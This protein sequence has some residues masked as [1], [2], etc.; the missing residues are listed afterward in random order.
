[1]S[2]ACRHCDRKRERERAL[3]VETTDIASTKKS[4]R[5][6]SFRE[7]ERERERETERQR[8][9]VYLFDILIYEAS[10]EFGKERAYGAAVCLPLPRV[11][12]LLCVRIIQ[13]CCR[14]QAGILRNSKENDRVVR[15][16][17]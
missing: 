2:V 13:I 11:V 12:A 16:A 7:R 4:F 14:D 15:S 1:M 3:R 8:E 5:E 10:K 9:A 17:W 6:R